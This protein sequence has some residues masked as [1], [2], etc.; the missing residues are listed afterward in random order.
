MQS[1]ALWTNLFHKIIKAKTLFNIES[2][3]MYLMLEVTLNYASGYR[4]KHRVL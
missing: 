4:T 2:P 3:Q 1:L